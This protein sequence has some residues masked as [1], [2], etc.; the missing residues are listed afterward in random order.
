M[1][2]TVREKSI[3][4][5]WQG[6]GG[7]CGGVATGV[8]SVRRWQKLPLCLTKPVTAGSKFRPAAG[9]G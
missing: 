5:A 1:L 4:F 6:L 8:P 2:R 9:Q 7:V 3:G